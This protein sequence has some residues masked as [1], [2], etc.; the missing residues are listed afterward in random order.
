MPLKL[1]GEL[2]LWM[3]GLLSASV[4]IAL[5]TANPTAANELNGNG[6]ARVEVESD[7]WTINQAN[8]TASNTAVIQFPVPSGNWQDP[9]HVGIWTAANDGDLL[10][11]IAL[12]DDV[13]PPAI[14]EDVEFAA[15]QL[16][17]SFPTDN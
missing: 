1:A 7:G 2:K 8:G 11:S 17:L 15:G 5:H 14:G 13:E 12:G 10:W 4:Y 3:D 16:T 6:Y 9:T